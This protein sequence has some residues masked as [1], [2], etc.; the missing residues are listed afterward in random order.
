MKASTPFI[1]EKG[2]DPNTSKTT[3]TMSCQNFEGDKTTD[4]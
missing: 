2:D 3:K 4:T 1:I